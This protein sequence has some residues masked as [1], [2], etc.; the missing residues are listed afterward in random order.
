MNAS[1]AS[2]DGEPAA[3]AAPTLRGDSPAPDGDGPIRLLDGPRHVTHE[4]RSELPGHHEATFATTD[5]ERLDRYLTD[6]GRAELLRLVDAGQH[7]FTREELEWLTTEPTIEA[8]MVS[9][10]GEGAEG[11]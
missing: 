2:V 11:G 7:A 3:T 10:A 8:L 6:K 1:N 9:M 4:D 5:G